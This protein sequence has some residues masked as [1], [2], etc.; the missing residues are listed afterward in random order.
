MTV[1][2][3]QLKTLIET[4]YGNEIF[5]GISFPLFPHYVEFFA[6]ISRFFILLEFSLRPGLRSCQ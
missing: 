4:I 1:L 2:A 3:K 6:S 5:L